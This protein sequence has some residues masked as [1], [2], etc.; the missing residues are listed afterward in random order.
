MLARRFGHEL[1]HRTRS[2]NAFCVGARQRLSVILVLLVGFR[3]RVF[4]ILFLVLGF[5]QLRLRTCGCCNGLF[6]FFFCVAALRLG[7]I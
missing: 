6:H 3:Q 1:L 2:G 5:A 4:H 7:I